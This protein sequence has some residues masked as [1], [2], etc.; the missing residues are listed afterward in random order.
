M[1]DQDT[2]TKT[3]LSDL[4]GSV[5]TLVRQELRLAQAE[6]AE[7]VN[8]VAAGAI[9]MVAGMLVTFA[10]LLVLLQALVAALAEHMATGWASLI[11]GVIV[12]AIGFGL[13]KYGQSSLKA[14]NLVPERTVR[15]VRADADLAMDK[16]K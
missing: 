10:A 11:V 1:V 9:G 4:V 13:L 6:G 12:A 3:L 7:K 15:Q 16:V 8:Q 14:T 2:G 5:Q